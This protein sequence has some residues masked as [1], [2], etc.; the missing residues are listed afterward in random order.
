MSRNNPSQVWSDPHAGLDPDDVPIPGRMDG[1][2]PRQLHAQEAATR[3]AY[4]RRAD[5]AREARRAAQPSPYLGGGALRPQDAP[6][7][8]RAAPNGAASGATSPVR[9]ALLALIAELKATRGEVSRLCD[10]LAATEVVPDEPEPRGEQEPRGERPEPVPRASATPKP[11]HPAAGDG[12]GVIYPTKE[13][14]S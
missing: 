8:P 12:G 7:P 9:A 6:Q 2:T 5:Y 1:L 4:D 13:E 10:L 14:Q 3:A 11:A